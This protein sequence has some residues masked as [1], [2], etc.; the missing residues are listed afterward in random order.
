MNAV[1]IK[2][3]DMSIKA[4]WLIV[5]V[6]LI[7]L[8]LKKAP[9]YIRCILWALVAV[10]LVFPFSIE[11]GLSLVPEADVNTVTE[12]TADLLLDLK[13]RAYELAESDTEQEN[14]VSV[15]DSTQN[16]TEIS[17]ESEQ[18][19]VIDMGIPESHGIDFGP[20]VNAAPKVWIL[21]V[22]GLITYSMVSLVLLKRK[23][24][25]SMQLD[26]NIYLCDGIDSPFIMGLI[27]PGIYLP[28]GISTSELEYVIAHEKAHLE[29]FDDWWK[30][31]GFLLLAIHWFNPLVWV[32]YILF[33]RDIELACDELVIKDMSADDKKAYSTAL[34]YY[35]VPHKNLV[36][37]PL[38]F[39]EVGVKNR[40][41]SIL[42]Y[43]KP[44]L[45]ITIVAAL[46]CVAVAVFF[47]T[48]PVAA[49]K[50][51]KD[52]YNENTIDNTEQTPN[53]LM[54]EYEEHLDECVFGGF[55][56]EINFTSK[57]HHSFNIY[58]NKDFY[59]EPV[60]LDYN[61]YGVYIHLEDSEGNIDT[62]EYKLPMV[63]KPLDSIPK[64]IIECEN[65]SNREVV[66]DYEVAVNN[67]LD[68]NNGRAEDLFKN[69]SLSEEN[70]PLFEV[71]DWN[72]YRAGEIMLT[73]PDG[74]AP[75]V[76]DV[77]DVVLNE[78]GSIRYQGEPDEVVFRG[79]SVYRLIDEVKFSLSNHSSIELYE[80]KRTMDDM[81]NTFYRGY[82]VRCYWA[83]T[84]GLQSVTYMFVIRTQNTN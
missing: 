21:G 59:I 71:G 48:S 55:F 22:L 38:A 53:I 54:E 28:S 64:V 32:A 45:R 6:I 74:Q 46:T 69:L 57:L 26:D 84:E 83:T 51:E 11:S 65:G 23:V 79:A 2:I 39:G 60:K 66:E 4:C 34:L 13:I 7:R 10:K 76:V 47:M 16:S 9:K 61:H 15:N 62:Y 43:T 56:G 33:S 78:D 80:H 70:T 1:F 12:A 40:V 58:Y 67:W 50:E 73:F 18:E 14:N 25:V 3:L 5:V 8:L 30:V 44:A 52:N 77:E 19:N 42:N 82:R 81:I 31:I 37:H 27:K 41:S 29:R 17:I 75:D 24:K 72:E 68:Q 36:S 49:E 20:I 63:R 35:S